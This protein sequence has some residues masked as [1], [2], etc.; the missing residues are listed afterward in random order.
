MQQVSTNARK[1]LAGMSS[2]QP[3]RANSASR[4]FD[5]T[6]PVQNE[7]ER[8]VNECARGSPGKDFVRRAVG[9]IAVQQISPVT[10][11]GQSRVGDMALSLS[12]RTQITSRPSTQA[13]TAASKKPLRT[14]ST[15]G[16]YTGLVGT[17]RTWVFAP[18]RSTSNACALRLVATTKQA[19]INRPQSDTRCHNCRL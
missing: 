5:E 18:I 13:M 16:F 6:H 2:T 9:R 10:R 3:C 12:S 4:H 8:N 19:I 11:H 14:L 1:R 15:L 17:T 7:H